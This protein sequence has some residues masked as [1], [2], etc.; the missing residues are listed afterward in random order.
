MSYLVGY[1]SV[2]PKKVHH[3]GASIPANQNPSCSDRTWLVSRDPNPNI[4]TGALVGGPS[5]SDSYNDARD[6]ALQGEPTTTSSALF[7][8][9][10]SGLDSNTNYTTLT[11]FT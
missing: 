3:R 6:N 11:S 8:G 4:A 2:Y 5:L 1:G 10:L 9:L 7:T